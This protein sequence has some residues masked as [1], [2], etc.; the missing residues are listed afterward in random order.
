MNKNNKTPM[1]YVTVKDSADMAALHQR[2]GVKI[3][4][5]KTM[6]PSYSIRSIYRHAKRSY[7]AGTE[8][9]RKHNHG[10]PSKLTTHDKRR[11]LRSIRR[12]RQI[13]GPNLQRYETIQ[14]HVSRWKL[15]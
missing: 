6:F 1:T 5:L 14:L 7:G 11:I 10:R 9:R 8:D 13:E 3:A 4:E 2:S 12:L 15:V